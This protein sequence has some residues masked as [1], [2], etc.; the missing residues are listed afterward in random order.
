[1][2]FDGLDGNLRP[3]DYHAVQD[4]DHEDQIHDD[5]EFNIIKTEIKKFKNREKRKII[6]AYLAD[7][8]LVTVGEEYDHYHENDRL[9]QGET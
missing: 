8:S 3:G 5:L 9:G 1:M 6:K 4:D 7:S 2:N